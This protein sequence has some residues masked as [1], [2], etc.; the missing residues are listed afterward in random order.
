M[1]NVRLKE[2]DNAAQTATRIEQ[3]VNRLVDTVRA[4]ETLLR[5]QMHIVRTGIREVFENV[6]KLCRQRA[7]DHGIRFVATVGDDVTDVP[8]IPSLL[9]QAIINLIANAQD[10]LERGG[11]TDGVIEL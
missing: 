3:N 8:V 10:A 7:E 2:Y 6:A 4:L 5:P 9:I 1:D 11:I